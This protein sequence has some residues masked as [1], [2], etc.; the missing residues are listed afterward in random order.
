M[1]LAEG[2]I[3]QVGQIRE[4]TSKA[5][6]DWAEGKGDQEAVERV[7]AEIVALVDCNRKPFDA[8]FLDQVIQK[9]KP[10]VSGRVWEFGLANGCVK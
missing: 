1:E 7:A 2:L 6:G 8:M 5:G 3:R 4:K 9:V 10:E